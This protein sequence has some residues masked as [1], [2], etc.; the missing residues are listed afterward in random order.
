V[1]DYYN[2]TSIKDQP[3]FAVTAALTYGSMITQRR[4]KTDQ[5]NYTNM[6]SI[7]VGET[8]C[9]K[10][11]L[12][13]VVE[14]IALA[15]NVNSLIGPSGY[16]SS[17]GV[18]TALV[19]KPAHLTIIDELG[20]QLETS[21]KEK[22]SNNENAFTLIMELF[23][24]A[25][26]CQNAPGYSNMVALTKQQAII[27]K[28]EKD[29]EDKE[30][31]ENKLNKIDIPE[32]ELY[33]RHP[34]LSILAMTT[35][36]NFYGSISAGMIRDG[37]LPRFIVVET[38]YGRPLSKKIKD[39]NVNVDLIKW[40]N[41]HIKNRAKIIVGKQTI[42]KEYDPKFA[43]DAKII[44]FSPECDSILEKYEMEL[45]TK[46]DNAG[47]LKDLYGKTK[48]I[49]MKL[50]LLIALSCESEKIL[51]EHVNWSIDYVTYYTDKLVE[52]L[53]Y[54]LA[55]SK[56]EAVCNDLLRIIQNKGTKGLALSE[57]HR[58]SR[59]AREYSAYQIKNIIIPSLQQY[60]GVQ[61]C[62]IK[63]DG[64]TSKR[65]ALVTKEIAKMYKKGDDGIDE[66]FE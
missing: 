53:K 40:T 63:K 41:N 61:Y 19:K 44:P 43:P 18:F 9:G 26:G 60:H 12:K 7:N 3:Q 35:P 49:T 10:E 2:A 22:N 38:E 14:E 31:K 25:N 21:K 6:Y 46:M 36:E 24:R 27:K 20:R 30:K 55:D 47:E 66:E 50:S 1:V 33:I 13:S 64:V 65:H 59:K 51:P 37:F 29:D 48:E 52:K 8:S 62:H 32:D 15:A 17:G 57:V 42:D 54:S 23:G 39:V 28:K 58:A 56:F 4:Y 34:A 16:T 5:N 45:N 11:R